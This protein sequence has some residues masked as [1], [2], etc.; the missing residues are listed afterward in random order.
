MIPSQIT[1]QIVSV[2]VHVLILLWKLTARISYVFLIVLPVHGQILIMHSVT[3]QPAAPT[4]T[5]LKVMGIMR[6]GNV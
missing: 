5:R 4:I 1:R 2:Y 3:V 6:R